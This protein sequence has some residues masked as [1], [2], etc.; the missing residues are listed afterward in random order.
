MAIIPITGDNLQIYKT[1]ARPKRIF[2]SSSLDGVTGSFYLNADYSKSVK[3]VDFNI[4]RGTYEENSVEQARQKIIE[5][6]TDEPENFPDLNATF[7][8]DV[9][10]DVDV[11]S[12]IVHNQ[13]RI[14]PNSQQGPDAKIDV[15]RLGSTVEFT[16]T[17]N[18]NVLTEDAV[19]RGRTVKVLN[20]NGD[21]FLTVADDPVLN[22]PD[23]NGF[24]LSFWVYHDKSDFE[25]SFGL[26]NKQKAGTTSGQQADREWQVYY[27]QNDGYVFRRY[28]E[29]INAFQG[30]IF[31]FKKG[32]T[33][34]ISQGWHHFLISD[35]PLSGGSANDDI[36]FYINGVFKST[37]DYHSLGYQSS[38]NLGGDLI[39]GAYSTTN[40][41]PEEFKIA[42]VG[43]WDR[44]LN[45]S[46]RQSVY[47]DGLTSVSKS[48]AEYSD[49]ASEH[50]QLHAAYRKN[51]REQYK[52][53]N[54][55]QNTQDEVSLVCSSGGSNVLTRKIG[56]KRYNFTRFS[57]RN[58]MIEID[59]H[60][61]LD[62]IFGPDSSGQ[63]TISAWITCTGNNTIAGFSRILDLGGNYQ[64]CITNA[65]RIG[66]YTIYEG[67]NHVGWKTSRSIGSILGLQD[68]N[69]TEEIPVHV[70]V[71]YNPTTFDLSLDP[72]P[73]WRE[74]DETPVFFVN[75]EKIE[76]IVTSGASQ[77]PAE[78]RKRINFQNEKSSI[79]N[80]TQ[81]DRPWI[82]EISELSIW[83]KALSW[84]NIIAIY[85]GTKK[86]KSGFEGIQEYMQL[87]KNT[88]QHIRQT[89]RQEV[90]RYIPGTR[91]E[92][93]FFHKFT[94]RNTLFKHYRIHYPTAHWSYTNY[95]SLNFFTS[96]AKD[97]QEND[98]PFTI[99]KNS[100][101]AY[102]AATSSLAAGGGDVN[103][104]APSSSFTFDF[105]I[106]PKG[107]THKDD[108]S[109]WTENY[110]PGC[111]L[112][113]SSCYAISLT[114]G[115]DLGP[116]GRPES[117]GLM[118]QLSSSADV[119]PYSISFNNHIPSTTLPEN[120][121]EP[122]NN[123]LSHQLAYIFTSSAGALKRDKWHHVSIRWGG[124]D[125]FN[126]YGNITIDGKIDS[127]FV[128]SEK[129]ISEAEIAK[130]PMNNKNDPNFSDIRKNIIM[131]DLLGDNNGG[132]SDP[133]ALFVGNYYEGTNIGNQQ[134]TLLFAPSIAE[135]EGLTALS[136]ALTG[137]GDI[138][139]DYSE[140]VNSVEQPEQADYSAF[141][142]LDE[143]VTFR[144]PLNAEIHDIKIYDHY[145]L[146]RQIEEQR[147]RGSEI[148][149]GLL[150]YV[151]P[152]FIK[153]SRSRSILQTPFQKMTGSTDTPFNSHLSFGVSGLDINLENF[154]KDFVTG[155][156]PRLF[157]LKSGQTIT[158]VDEEGLTANMIMYDKPTHRKR[159]Y[160]ILP[161]DNGS[162]YPNF[163]LL[164]SGSSTPSP[165]EDHPE[166]R[167][168][169]D[170]GKRDL[171][172]I[173]LNNMLK[174]E[175][176]IL[177]FNEDGIG[178]M[179]SA[180]LAST[181]ENPTRNPQIGYR[182]DSKNIMTV[183]QRTGD[184]SSN[185]V[186]FFDISNLFYGDRIYPGSVV[187]TDTA[188]TGSG[189]E[190]NITLKDDGKGNLYRDNT[191]SE[192]ATWSSVGNVLYDDGIIAIKS[193]HLSLF[194]L[195][196]YTLAFEGERNIH[197]MEYQIP[198]PAGLINSSSNPQYKKLIPSDYDSENADEF[199]YMSGLQLHDN[200]LNVV[201]RS[202]FAQPIIKRDG[203]R[204]LV[205]IRVDF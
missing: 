88:G 71:S 160:T 205:K 38:E 2:T 35:G 40:I 168:I 78:T 149:P 42:E 137:I 12:I 123:A 72:E 164:A 166:G 93:N 172:M 102:P 48:P 108:D 16:A 92:D 6:I 103:K 188:M 176:R 197:T 139:L 74:S 62:E 153:E 36:R 87:V 77:P 141:N 184:D 8:V 106:K 105:F 58:D 22:F 30:R 134:V 37:D 107:S 152:F 169:N 56:T 161:C 66:F 69:F 13:A 73:P 154:V 15:N 193:P 17:E 167:F 133:D 80:R 82:G 179:S 14:D 143:G 181:P 94:I 24:S 79:G 186:V 52:L 165:D 111:I 81:G 201:M 98:S 3:D 21:G 18:G 27:K 1:V 64:L 174:G 31:K 60:D 101:I 45:S 83:N 9:V 49:A 200:N 203:D 29:S 43:L 173:S 97:G 151:P 55:A 89:K 110:M 156:Y 118:L 25:G 126:G 5:I 146:N 202:N 84:Q 170:L 131:Q 99:P 142:S 178:T 159:N 53:Y 180:I 185:E 63:I 44:V 61:R 86:T 109:Q 155:E 144:H 148:E 91:M 147:K 32:D 68:N 124:T 175:E 196:G 33:P 192:P 177:S 51:E 187:L 132:V 7:S 59:N 120:D 182:L 199:V 113:M 19:I 204:I 39:I 4:T 116:D 195:D 122:P 128:L 96:E 54:I 10:G 138:D 140:D 117:Y 41:I 127:P 189:G 115:S 50:L 191:N 75:G 114:P 47:Q 112:H 129:V 145:R 26:V 190:I 70:A 100:V 162:F 157:Q 57:N 85:N 65:G 183:F 20:G 198:A 76:G 125:S 23:A 163:E 150:F 130:R 46:E 28:D 119:P 194:G 171:R 104:L 34:N 95:H 11:K 136:P 121:P 90:R 158:Q 135:E 67:T